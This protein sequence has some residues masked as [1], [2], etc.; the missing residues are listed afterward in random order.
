[1]QFKPQGSRIQVL[2][3]RG[4]DKQKR[5]AIVRMQ[6]ALDAVSYAPSDGLLDN[7]T[8]LEKTELQAYVKTQQQQARNHQQQSDCQHIAQRIEAAAG[9]LKSGI[10]LT[11]DQ[12]AAIWSA[13]AALQKALK[14]QGHT[15]KNTKVKQAVPEEKIQQEQGP[16]LING[17]NYLF[18][19]PGT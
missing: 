4:Y 1:M 17:Q 15:K 7:L 12:A 8:D 16:F 2:A 18:K 5:R 14:A 6:G 9:G 19:P 13:M 3:Y 11:E 10:A